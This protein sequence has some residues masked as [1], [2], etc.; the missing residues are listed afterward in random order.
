VQDV[1]LYGFNVPF[2]QETGYSFSKTWGRQGK[3]PVL[4]SGE[5]HMAVDGTQI[6]GN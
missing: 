1:L 3:L 5:F 6:P 2:L 4:G